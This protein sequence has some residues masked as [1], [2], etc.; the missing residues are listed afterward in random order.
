MEKCI[1]E[2]PKC[3]AFGEIGLD[4]SHAS[5]SEERAFQRRNFISLL[6]LARKH[7]H[8][9]P[10]VLHLRNSNVPGDKDCAFRVA[11]GI[12]RNME[13]LDERIHIHSFAGDVEDARVWY[14]SCRRVMFGFTA[15]LLMPECQ[16]RLTRAVEWIPSRWLLAESDAPHLKPPN[17]PGPNHPWNVHQVIDRFAEIKELN[18]PQMYK[19]I[20][21]NTRYFYKL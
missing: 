17:M 20:E 15:M 19:T 12:L 3:V 16:E 13:M 10:I 1:V 11:L 6:S 7:C 8:G 14:H 18:L 9:K 4:Y 2:N 5:S 21:A